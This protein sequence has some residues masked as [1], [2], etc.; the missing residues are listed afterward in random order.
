MA[1]RSKRGFAA[2]SPQQQRE[3]ARRGGQAAHKKGTAHEFTS[4]EARIAG[5]KGGRALSKNR[6]YMSEIGRKG[7][8]S[9]GQR[10]TKSHQRQVA[11]E[12]NSHE[13]TAMS[14]AKER[15]AP[16]ATDVIRSDHRKVEEL[17]S[18][19]EN[20][21]RQQL[22]QETLIKQ[23]CRELD[24]HTQLEEEIFYPTI[25]AA[26]H[27]EGE[28]LVAEALTD[29]ETIDDLVEQLKRM[30][31]GESSCA[32]AMRQLKQCVQ[33]HVEKEEK[34]MLPKA[35]QRLGD[36]LG[37]LGARMVQCKQELAR[38]ES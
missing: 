17:F 8:Q 22:Q 3:I 2:M 16:R 24:I 15:A 5:H 6:Q 32:A 7:G 20:A 33:R 13:N 34:E 18:R 37:S 36:Q 25:Q 26:F 31:P 1:G 21:N 19:F 9:A 38:V 28:L 29:H 27:E 23:I 11:N 30:S 4:D 35:E 10:E 12:T 14:E